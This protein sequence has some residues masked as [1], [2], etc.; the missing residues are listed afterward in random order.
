MN[1][2]K[3]WCKGKLYRKHL[4]FYFIEKWFPI[5]HENQSNLNHGALWITAVSQVAASLACSFVTRL[6]PLKSGFWQHPKT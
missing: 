4:Y 1:H 3:D 2:S 5:F 6:E